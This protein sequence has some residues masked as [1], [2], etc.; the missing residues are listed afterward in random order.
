[1]PVGVQMLLMLLAERHHHETGHLAPSVPDLAIQ[2]H[3]TDRTIQR[4]LKWLFRARIIESVQRKAARRPSRGKAPN[5]SNLYVIRP[6]R[7]GALVIAPT[8]PDCLVVSLSE[9]PFGDQF[10]GDMAA[11]FRGDTSVA[12]GVTPVSPKKGLHTRARGNGREG[13]QAEPAEQ[14]PAAAACGGGAAVSLTEEGSGL[15][16]D[17]FDLGDPASVQL[18]EDADED[19]DAGGVPGAAGEAIPS[20]A[21]L[22]VLGQPQGGAAGRLGKGS[23]RLPALGSMGGSG[24]RSSARLQPAQ[25]VATMAPE[26]R[27]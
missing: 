5:L 26:G 25:R 15:G 4:R 20:P 12:V 9:M 24:E 27:A 10:R 7:E 8:R 16:G 14:G 17:V 1:M 13:H 22:M 6:Y 11:E 18:L 3:T 21:K 2:M 23:R 19:G